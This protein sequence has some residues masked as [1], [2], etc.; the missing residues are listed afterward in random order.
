MDKVDL[1]NKE[2]KDLPH[3]GLIQ[4]EEKTGLKDDFFGLEEGGKVI[5][6]I[7]DLRIIKGIQ[8]VWE[9]KQGKIGWYRAATQPETQQEVNPDPSDK[10][11]PAVG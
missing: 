2:K 4:E 10:L 9:K 8:E 5:P 7:G 3:A 1:E 11:A 6:K